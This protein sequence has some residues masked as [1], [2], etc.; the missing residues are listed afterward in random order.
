MAGQTSQHW[1]D[2]LAV[3]LKHQTSDIQKMMKRCL[4]CFPIDCIPHQSREERVVTRLKTEINKDQIKL[5][6][7]LKSERNSRINLLQSNIVQN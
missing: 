6:R 3:P 2:E 4:T 5:F 7:E 1:L